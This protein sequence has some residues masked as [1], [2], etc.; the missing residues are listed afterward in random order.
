MPYPLGGSVG[1]SSR[2]PKGLGFESR[3]GHIPWFLFDS[4]L[5]WEGEAMD[6]HIDVLHIDVSLSLPDSV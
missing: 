5:G 2:T 6:S 3:S 1:A 4:R